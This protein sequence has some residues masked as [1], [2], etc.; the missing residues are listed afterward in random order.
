M[1][2]RYERRGRCAIVTLDRPQAR[3]AIDADTALGIEQAI[4]RFEEDEQV[5]AAVIAA[6][7]PVFCAGADLKAIG[8]GEAE[9]LS[10]ARGGFAGIVRRERSKPLIAAVDGPALAGG[11]EIVLT[12]DLV[13][14]S[15]AAS[16]GVPEVQRGLVAAAGALFRLP[17][18]IPEN[19]AIELLL[20]GRRM[21]AAEAHRHGLVNR[22]CE[23][24]AALAGALE[25]AG[26]IAENAPLAVRASRSAVL[27]SRGLSE[28]GAWERTER[29]LRAVID[30]ADV[31]EGVRAF[32]EK[33]APEWQGR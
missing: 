21:D 9:R 30:S 26:A 15:T 23:P 24:G 33:R 25:L 12:C 28:G 8:A 7:P 27:E 22:L 16:F 13:V 4:D 14:A 6:S 32:V 11:M 20:T 2:V 29:A 18:R 1:A 19:V 31:Q 17:Q 3:N 10:T 5:R